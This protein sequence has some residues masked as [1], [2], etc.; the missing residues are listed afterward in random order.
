MGPARY[1][2]RITLACVSALALVVMG[3]GAR[4]GLETPGGPDR[5]D[6]RVVCE[7]CDAGP[8][9]VPSPE[10]CND[11]DDDCDGLS[12]EG[13]RSQ[14][15]DCRPGCH[16]LVVPGDETWDTSG[17]ASGVEVDDEGRL[18]LNRNREAHASAWIANMAFGTITRLDTRDGAQVGEFDSALLD[19][20]NHAEPVGV[21]CDR[22]T[23][24]GN[25]PSRTAVDRDGSVYIANRAFGGQGTVT[26]IAGDEEL[27]V[28]RNGNGRVDSS[29]DVDG[30]GVIERDVAGEFLG[31][32]DE[33][34]VWTADVGG[35]DGVPRALAIAADGRV[36]VGVHNERR[37]VELDPNDGSELRSI[38]TPRLMPYGAAI[39]RDGTLWLADTFTSLLEAGYIMAVDTET[40]V[41]GPR[42]RAGGGSSCSGAYGIA[43]D[44]QNRVWMAGFTCNRTWR[45]DPTE[46]EWRGFPLPVSET[47]RGIAVDDR[48]FVYVAASHSAISYEPGDVARLVRFNG[49]DG[50]EME[51]FELPGV[52]SIGVGLD[53]ERRPWVVNEAS[54]T[55]TRLDPESGEMREFPVGE[56]PYTYSD[57]T[58]FALRTFTDPRG[59]EREVREGC[60]VGPTEWERLR[61]TGATPPSTALEI[62]LRTAATEAELEI[63]EWRGPFAADV[64]LRDAPGPLG[65]G[66]VLQIE[67]QLA[68]DDPRA[69]PALTE[70]VVQYHCPAG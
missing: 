50:S 45:Y 70:V 9:C 65:P 46:D 10:V 8:I 12:D 16:L 11:I 48:G 17:D 6:S 15:D 4:T 40:G 66:P 64:D 68:S 62:R 38:D 63:A 31:Q 69:S 53:H 3:C 23:R 25:C 58:G 41:A 55:A 24:S 47:T 26:K 35:V 7:D 42:M 5:P 61:W 33:C 32:E 60:A 54:A 67:A 44:G 59:F 49:D 20:T 56:R 37:V 29:R 52:G 19:G 22:F 28:D 57:F 13:V 27:C 30:D 21:L 34:I 39:S 2:T 14:C 18:V 51:V 36:W 43:V 1:R